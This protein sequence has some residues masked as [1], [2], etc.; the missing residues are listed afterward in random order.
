MYNT[1]NNFKEM[2][3]ERHTATKVVR[4]SFEL[5]ETFTEDFK[6]NQDPR[7]I[8]AV[9]VNLYGYLKQVSAKYFRLD[10]QDK[11]SFITE[12]IWK[13]LMD[14]EPSRGVP[15]A[16]FLAAY[17]NRRCYAENKMRENLVRKANYDT[18]ITCSIEAMEETACTLHE[19]SPD[20]YVAEL[21]DYI[22]SANL[23]NNEMLYCKI[24]SEEN[25]RMSDS[26]I[27]RLMGVSPANINYIRKRL[28]MKIQFN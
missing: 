15:Y 28:G 7:I 13:S 20:Y 14:F 22:N 19:G 16:S 18:G 23:N 25:H 11:A 8:A 17:V 2:I 4:K 6:E 26:E 1:Y 27:A 21:M 3:Q 12:E 5:G 9:Y 24:V 10:P